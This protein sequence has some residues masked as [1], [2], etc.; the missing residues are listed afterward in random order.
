M[1]GKRLNLQHFEKCGNKLQKYWK[2]ILDL[3]KEEKNK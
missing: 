2:Q 1:S 3:I